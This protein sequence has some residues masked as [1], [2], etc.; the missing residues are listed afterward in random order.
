MS[1]TSPTI[2]RS[3]TT[4]DPNYNRLNQYSTRPIQRL[5][6]QRETTSANNLDQGGKRGNFNRV[7]GNQ[8]TVVAPAIRN[9]R[10]KSRL[11]RSRRKLKIQRSNTDGRAFRTGSSSRTK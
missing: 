2:T 7:N 9:R 8:L 10:S 11:D 4:T 5:T 3:F 6:L 1:R